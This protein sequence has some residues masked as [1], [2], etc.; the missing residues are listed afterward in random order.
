MLLVGCW[1]VV[2][3]CLIVD[4]YSLFVVSCSLFVGRCLLLFVMPGLLIV[5][6]R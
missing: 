3:C 2:G 6:C 5:V 4:D 1:L